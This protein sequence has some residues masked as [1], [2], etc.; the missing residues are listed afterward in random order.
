MKFFKLYTYPYPQINEV[1][2]A[3]LI[4]LVSKFAVSSEVTLHR[5]HIRAKTWSKCSRFSAT[6]QTYNSLRTDLGG[7]KIPRCSGE[8]CSQTPPPPPSPVA[9]S[10]YKE[11]LTNAVCPFCAPASAMSWLRHCLP[12]VLVASHCYN[13]EAATEQP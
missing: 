12:V 8:A 5:A 9:S 7:A 3:P 11:I 13:D 2:Y 1:L 6:V 4:S 10:F